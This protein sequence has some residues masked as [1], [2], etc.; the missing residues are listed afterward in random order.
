MAANL[1]SRVKPLPATLRVARRAG[2]NDTKTNKVLD[3]RVK[4]LPATLRVARRA[5][6]NDTKVENDTKE[7]G[8]DTKVYV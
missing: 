7:S 4:P 8:N 6:E 3:S 1:D 2:E 5:G